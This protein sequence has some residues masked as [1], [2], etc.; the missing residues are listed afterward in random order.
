MNTSEIF[1]AMDSIFRHKKIYYDV[2]PCDALKTLHV[3][4]PVT[5]LVVNNREATHA[6]EHWL[7]LMIINKTLYFFCSYGLGIENYSPY[8]KDFAKREHLQVIQN[9]QVLQSINSNVCGQYCIFFLYQMISGCCP[10]SVYCMFS[11]NVIKNDNM[12]KSFVKK[13]CSTP[14][15]R[16]CNQNCCCFIAK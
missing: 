6:G 8:F 3:T 10:M 14:K 5:C 13:L 11:K 7:G 15:A 1:G 2:L 4:N 16:F 12:V 9:K